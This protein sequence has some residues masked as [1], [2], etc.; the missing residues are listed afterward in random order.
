MIG[1]TVRLMSTAM[2]VLE[3]SYSVLLLGRRSGGLVEGCV[4][5][6][7]LLAFLIG[8]LHLHLSC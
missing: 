7:V 6:S 3:L 8:C 4:F 1:D 5:I 2:N